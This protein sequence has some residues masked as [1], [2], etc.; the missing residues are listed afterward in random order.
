[1]GRGSTNVQTVSGWL[2]NREVLDALAALLES[3]DVK[4]AIDKTYAL[5]EAAE[6][7][8]HMLGHRAKGKIVITIDGDSRIP[9]DGSS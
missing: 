1:M 4:V 5:S 2:P 6:A 9:K 8:T 3:G 7:V